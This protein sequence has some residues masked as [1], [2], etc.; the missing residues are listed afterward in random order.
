MH[1]CFLMEIQRRS[2]NL[3]V[4]VYYQKWLEAAEKN[5]D[6]E[7]KKVNVVRDLKQVRN[8]LQSAYFEARLT[9]D[10]FFHLIEI[11]YET[12]FIFFR[13]IHRTTSNRHL[14]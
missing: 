14:L 2:H 9:D 8:T 12:E 5:V 4:N 3:P 6:D 1:K 10:T 7:E 13:H 11:A